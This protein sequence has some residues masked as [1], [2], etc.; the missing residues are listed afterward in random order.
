MECDLKPW[1]RRVFILDVKSITI[2]A[3]STYSSS[4]PNFG[5]VVHVTLQCIIAADEGLRSETFV[6]MLF[7]LSSICDSSPAS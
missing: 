3:L 7:A 2:M 4:V 5:S 6:Y 1:H